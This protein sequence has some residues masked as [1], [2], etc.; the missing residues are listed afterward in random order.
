[1]YSL[2]SHRPAGRI[3]Y[4]PLLLAVV[5]MSALP[6]TLENIMYVSPLFRMRSFADLL[7]RQPHVRFCRISTGCQASPR[8]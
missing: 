2:T 7:N 5:L 1:M 8:R 6:V 4:A 3:A